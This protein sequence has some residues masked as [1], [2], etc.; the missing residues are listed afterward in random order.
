MILASWTLQLSA[1][2][3]A[4]WRRDLSSAHCATG[5]GALLLLQLGYLL[6]TQP[7]ISATALHVA[8]ALTL[9]KLVRCHRHDALNCT[10]HVLRPQASVAAVADARPSNR[11]ADIWGRSFADFG[12]VLRG[13]PPFTVGRTLFSRS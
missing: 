12:D 5:F 3:L 8:A 1:L 6:R 9:F 2:E 7:T 10:P 13:R 4:G 11:F